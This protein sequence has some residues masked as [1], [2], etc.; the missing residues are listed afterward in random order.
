MQFASLTWTGSRFVSLT[1]GALLL[2]AVRASA[3]DP[4][5]YFGEANAAQHRAVNH[6]LPLPDII[7]FPEANEPRLPTNEPRQPAN[8]PRIVRLPP[9][10][11]S[12]APVNQGGGSRWEFGQRL[13]HLPGAG[14]LQPNPPP[15]E[16]DPPPKEP[17]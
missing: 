4:D 3:G 17:A 10:E 7:R 12:D 16:K 9:V 13:A 2:L 5:H 14:G 6:L 8:E 11:G 15:A 1:I